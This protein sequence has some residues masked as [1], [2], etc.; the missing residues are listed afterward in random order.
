MAVSTAALFD[1][2]LQVSV[3][4]VLAASMVLERK[5][6]MRLHGHTMVAAVVLNIVSFVAV[7]GPAW[8]SVGE[9]GT[10]TMG[11]VALAHVGTGALAFLLSIWIAGSWFLQ[12][13]VLQANT[14]K[15]MRCYG[16]KIPMW[17]TLVLWVASL[18]FGIVLFLMVNT[19]ILGSFPIQF[20]G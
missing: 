3:L 15:F 6:K 12:L 1:L 14:P 16:Q 11:M 9:G 2:A 19:S 20:G 13:T 18:V 4:V 17:A 8:D 7:M 10:G 5:K